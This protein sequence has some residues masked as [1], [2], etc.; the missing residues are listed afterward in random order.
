MF[1]SKNFQRE[2]FCMWREISVEA[3]RFV[4]YNT[5]TIM[6]YWAI[7]PLIA[8][9]MWPTSGQHGDDR[10]QVCPM[11]ATWNLLSRSLCR[12]AL[13]R[14]AKRLCLSI[15]VS[16]DTTKGSRVYHLNLFINLVSA[17][18]V[19]LKFNPIVLLFLRY[20]KYRFASASTPMKWIRLVF[21]YMHGWFKS[22]FAKWQT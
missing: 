8:R 3:G 19:F 15:A 10:T 2:I 14:G 9:F 13:R 18:L 21:R 11:L 12:Y 22:R 5:H 7:Y 6:L 16:N 20:H 17:L 4:K 1:N